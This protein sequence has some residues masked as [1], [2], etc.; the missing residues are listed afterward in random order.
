MPNPKIKI[1]NNSKVCVSNKDTK[2]GLFKVIAYSALTSVSEGVLSLD[3]GIN[4]I[5]YNIDPDTNEVTIDQL[6]SIFSYHKFILKMIVDDTDTYVYNTSVSGNVEVFPTSF[7]N[8]SAS[9]YII[10]PM[11]VSMEQPVIFTYPPS[12]G[13]ITLNFYVILDGNTS[14]RGY[15]SIFQIPVIA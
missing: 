13:Q 7:T 12:A 5:E 6:V 4:S 10:N 14:Y 15:P 11:E 1:T 8:Y 2:N 3:Y 9:K